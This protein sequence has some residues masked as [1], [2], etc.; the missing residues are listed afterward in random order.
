VAFYH[1][2]ATA[3]GQSLTPT[4]VR[5]GPWCSVF[6]K[7]IHLT[8]D[9]EVVDG[10]G[11]GWGGNPYFYAEDN[12]GSL[13]ANDGSS[14]V[15]NSGDQ[16]LKGNS[17]PWM[18]GDQILT[19]DTTK[20]NLEYICVEMADDHPAAKMRADI[21]TKDATIATKI[22]DIATKDAAI[23]TKDATIATK[24]AD[25]ATKDA[26]IATK[27]T[28]IADKNIEIAAAPKAKDDGI[29]DGAAAGIGVGCF[30]GG[31]LV[32][33]II[34]SMILCPA[35]RQQNAAVTKSTT[36]GVKVEQLNQVGI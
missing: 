9:S 4:L 19:I 26:A 1:P 11:T 31:L 27:D 25:I 7:D 5:A 29:E 8:P 15:A 28:E 21:A 13:L 36:P 10:Y 24:I 18:A 22:A 33:A 20:E 12:D 16:I 14:L 17:G 30:L 6:G 23:A 2:F 3:Q 35:A 34:I 32:G